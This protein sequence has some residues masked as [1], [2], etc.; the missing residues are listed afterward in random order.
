MTP[1]SS[2]FREA[3]AVQVVLYLRVYDILLI[4]YTFFPL[5]KKFGTEHAHKILRN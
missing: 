4:A 5:G 2:E 3:G 1:R